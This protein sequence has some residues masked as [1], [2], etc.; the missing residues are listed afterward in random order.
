MIDFDLKTFASTNWNSFRDSF[1]NISKNDKGKSLVES[2]NLIYNFD[3]ITES[4][5]DNDAKPTSADA[6][7]C[8]KN[9][10]VLIEFK[11]GFHQII[12]KNNFD[13]TQCTCDYIKEKYDKN[14]Y[15]K[16][17][18]KLLLQN[19][20][21]KIEEL[22]RSI[23]LKAI[24]SYITL[25]KTIASKCESTNPIKLTLLV[26]IDAVETDVMEDIMS[27]AAGPAHSQP[28]TQK[29]N[30][31]SRLKQSLSRFVIKGNYPVYYDCILV[32]GS[33]NFPNQYLKSTL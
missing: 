3:K 6:L 25:D 18:G 21:L 28:S 15:C 33:K 14:V 11:S 29:S 19:Q 24:E 16:D 31:I 4:L 20:E 9:E 13:K 1:T 27:D 8:L 22:T 26:I 30:H 7:L 12:T 32:H 5:F 2:D 23:Q 10:M 17:Y